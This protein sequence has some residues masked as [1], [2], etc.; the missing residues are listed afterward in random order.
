MIARLTRR[1]ALSMALT[2]A[3]VPAMATENVR[4]VVIDGYPAGALWVKEYTNFF[5]PEV[6]KRLAE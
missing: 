3:A 4:A 1:T 5:N 6:D 2:V